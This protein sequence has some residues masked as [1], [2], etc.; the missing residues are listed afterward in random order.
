M[1]TI[2]CIVLALLFAIAAGAQSKHFDQPLADSLAKWVVVDQIAAYVQKGDFKKMNHEQWLHY[3]DSV[4]STHQVLLKKIFDKY[5][6]PGY[7]LVG[8][9]GSNNFWL[10]VQHCDKTPEFQLEVLK[11]MKPELRKNNA[12]S[13]NFAYL[14]DR[15]NLNLGK[16]Q[17]YGTQVTYRL[18]S[19][20][21]IPKP[22]ADSL[23]VNSRRKEVGLEPIED[24][25]NMM[26]EMHFEM[27]KPF[28]EG[29]GIHKP[30]LLKTGN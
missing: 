14:T 26:S 25:L 15:V 10:M 30:K 29:R 18:D 2:S 11:A 19:C 4:F 23:N 28:Y 1:K 13:K 12:D 27:N 3:K 24:Y 20:Q 9:Q 5:G 22:L 21:A 17:I 8:K 16:K 7:D 6:F